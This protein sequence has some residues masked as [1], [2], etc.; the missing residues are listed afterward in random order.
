MQVPLTGEELSAPV[1]LCTGSLPRIL[2][3]VV[4]PEPEDAGSEG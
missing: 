2:R 3:V 4:L 1:V